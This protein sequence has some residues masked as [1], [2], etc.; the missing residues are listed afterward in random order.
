M[1]VIS[2]NNVQE[3]L[4]EGIR[5]LQVYGSKHSSRNGDVIVAPFPVTTHYRYPDQ[6]VIFWPERNAN[7]VF[8]LFESLWMI[9]GQND[10]AYVKQF[11]K[12]MET[13][14]DDGETLH[15]AYGYRWRR[16]FDVEGG[17]NPNLPDQL[18]TIIKRLKRYPDDRRSVLTM[19][20]PVADLNS[21][22]KD[23][24]CLSGDTTLWSPEC[25]LSLENVA[26]LFSRGLI[27][28][29]PVYTV[30]VATCAQTLGWATRVWKSGRKPLIRLDFDDGSFLKLTRDHVLFKR[31]RSALHTTP[32]QAGRLKVG[33]R[34][35]ASRKWRSEPKGQGHE[36][37]KKQ[38]NHNTAFSNFWA[39]H[40][41]YA[42]LLW[43]PIPP[44]HDVHH[45]NEIKTQ[46]SEHNIE[47]LSASAHSRLHRIGDKNPMRHLSK[48]Q[49]K[50]RAAKQAQSLRS[51]WKGL[52]N[53]ARKEHSRKTVAGQTYEGRLRQIAAVTGKKHTAESKLR[54]SETRRHWWAQRDNH[55]IVAITDCGIEDVYDFTVRK[56]HTALVG[57]GIVAHNCNT[58]AYFRNLNGSLNLTV[59]CRSNDLIWGAY[60]ANA[61]H[62]SMLLEY[63]AGATGLKVGEMWQISNNYHA[64]VELF[65]KLEPL[66]DACRSFSFGVNFKD[67]YEDGLKPFPIMNDYERW[68]VELLG[69][70]EDPNTALTAKNDFFPQVAWP[71]WRAHECYKEKQYEAAI[72]ELDD[73]KAQDWKT[74]CIEWLMRAA[75]R[76]KRAQDDGPNHEGV[77]NER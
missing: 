50:V 21:D 36:R 28:R 67:P 12:R 52:S 53:K 6:R 5:I 61:V 33:D 45:K 26:Q 14:S 74:A 71:M 48:E 44:N 35:L 24:P 66:A 22:S 43:G 69:F 27:T 13:F 4:P 31:G 15:G 49:H 64:Y 51:Y 11:V 41:A 3:A 30:D 65:E 37:M 20:D 16:H 59:C 68:D 54:M 76:Q 19:W 34:I 10:L 7:P 55:K 25:D 29:W 18:A 40:R 32:T 46:N 63:V 17:G 75:E 38:L 39:T 60:G 42:E 47:V 56:T 77:I 2:V 73:C 70:L 8:H 1:K 23:Q 9:A 72:H 62:F 58:H 57:S